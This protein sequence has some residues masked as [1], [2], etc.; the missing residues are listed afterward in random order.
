[1]LCLCVLP[2]LVAPG[3]KDTFRLPK[4]VLFRAE[5]IVLAGIWVVAAIERWRPLRYRRFELLALAI[6]TWSAITTLLSTNRSRSLDAFVTVLAGAVIFLA[7]IGLARRRRNVGLLWIAIVPALINALVGTLQELDIWN[8][9]NLPAELPHHLRS[10]AL[11]GNPNDAGG[12][13]AAIALAALAASFALRNRRV[14]FAA[15]ACVLTIGLIVNQTLTG[16]VALLVAAMA[17]LALRSWRVFAAGALTTIVV[18]FIATLVFSPLRER[19]KNVSDWLREGNYNAITTQRLTPFA[20]ALMMARDHPLFGVGPGCFSWQY[21]PY[22]LKAEG[23]YPALRASANRATN[24]GEVHNDHL[25]VLAEGGVPAYALLLAAVVCTAAIS[26]RKRPT[27]ADETQRF[28]SFL[29]LPL[30]CGFLVLA[31]AQFPL[32]L[33]AVFSQFLFLSA[34]CVGWSE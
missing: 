22:K 6:V 10:T 14:L 3:V 28:A 19:A 17:M 1:M 30:A 15:A 4:D 8:P 27:A 24:F 26:I 23:L 21:F 2:L 25:Q 13:L 34:L 33:T 11:I 5:A 32:E 31:L 16:I 18:I 7:T 12:Y 9:F 20:A 29:A